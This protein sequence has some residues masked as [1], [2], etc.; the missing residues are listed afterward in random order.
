MAGN[1]HDPGARGRVRLGVSHLIWGFDLSRPDLLLRFLD[2]AAAIGYEGV[3]CF[4]TT[5]GFWLTRP[6]EFRAQLEKRRLDL[7]GVILRPGLDFVA[8]TRLVKWMAEVGADVMVISGRDGRQEDWDISLP[9]LQRHGEIA[10][11]HGV[12]AVYHHHT[13]WIAETMEQA[14][15]LLRETDPKKLGGML[16]CGHA[17]KDF[18]G[19]SA[20]EYFER[21][22]DRIKYVEFKDWTPETDLGTEVGRGRCDFPAVTAALKK[23]GYK[24]WI[25]VEQNPSGARNGRPSDDPKASSQESYRYITEKLALGRR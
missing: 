16:D 14:E 20:Q 24:G 13:D 4:D 9:I 17:T 7:A 11:E 12:Q 6:H 21:N 3:L 8:T 25:T 22:H 18:V 5:V 2:D 1:R 23:H 15:R 19:H 10:A